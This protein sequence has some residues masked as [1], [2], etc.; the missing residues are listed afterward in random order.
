[1]H[2]KYAQ[3][4]KLTK[5]RGVKWTMSDWINFRC[6]DVVWVGL[7]AGVSKRMRLMLAPATPDRFSLVFFCAFYFLVEIYLI[8]SVVDWSLQLYVIDSVNFCRSTILFHIEHIPNG[9]KQLMQSIDYA[10]TFIA[11]A[12]QPN[13][14][15]LSKYWTPFFPKR[16]TNSQYMRNSIA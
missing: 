15:Q 2:S 6:F 16:H 1:M 4:T 7:R 10:N 3:S 12:F 9:G 8:G 14:Y 13:C 11:F 5:S